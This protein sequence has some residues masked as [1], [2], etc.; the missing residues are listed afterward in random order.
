ML[1]SIW[2]RNEDLFTYTVDF[3]VLAVGYSESR[4]IKELP[5]QQGLLN[6]LTCSKN[7]PVLNRSNLH[8]LLARHYTSDDFSNIIVFDTEVETFRWMRSPPC[9]YPWMSLLELDG[10]LAM[11]SSHDGIVIDIY[12]I[13]DYEAEVWAPTYQINLSALEASPQ[14]HL[15]ARTLRKIATLNERELLIDHPGRVL[16]CDLDGKFLGKMECD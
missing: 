4:P 12:G 14:L 6:G 11:C 9:R 3:H 1:Y 7:A 13:S 15:P 16:H 10:T 8:W 5:L 2:T